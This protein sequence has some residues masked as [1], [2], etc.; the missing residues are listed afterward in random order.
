MNTPICHKVG[1]CEVI[2]SGA[3]VSLDVA[4]S[5]GQF[6]E[7]GRVSFTGGSTHFRFE[8]TSI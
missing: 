6:P 3:R 1:M 2:K 4:G 8:Y 5:T 7:P